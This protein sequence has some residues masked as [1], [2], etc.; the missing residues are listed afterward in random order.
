MAALFHLHKRKRFHLNLEPF[1][2]P[3]KWK[4]FLDKIIYAA[5]IASPVF[6]IPQATKIWINQD[7]TGVSAIS[8]TGFTLLAVIWLLYG[9]AHKEK[10]LI[11]MYIGLVIIQSFVALG[12]FIYG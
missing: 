2:H 7:A 6:V 10:P 3:K 4:K 12:A 1:P 5:G 9:I 11:V 8:W